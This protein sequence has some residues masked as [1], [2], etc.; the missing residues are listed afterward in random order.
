MWSASLVPR[1]SPLAYV[2]TRAINLAHDLWTHKLIEVRGESL[3]RE[4]DIKGRETFFH[5]AKS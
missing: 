3:S 1:L 2:H 5:M 4:C